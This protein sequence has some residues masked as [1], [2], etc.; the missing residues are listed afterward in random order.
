M[1]NIDNKFNFFVPITFEKAQ[2]KQG[3]KIMKI[4]GIASTDEKDSEGEELIP[5]GFVLDRF[6]SSGLINYNHGAKNSAAAVIG[7]PTVA[8]ITPKGEL[9]V[10][11][12][13]YSGHPLAESVY[14]LAETFLKN[15]SKRRLGFSIEGRALE[16]DIVNPK[17]ITKA[18]ITGLAVT[19]TP[20]NTST[21]LDI[22]KGEQKQDFIEYEYDQEDILKKSEVESEYLYEFKNNDITF[23]ITKSFEVVDIEKAQKGKKERKVAKVMKEW[24]EGKLK[25]GGSGETVTNRDQAIAIAMSEAGINKEKAMDI[26][27]T[28]PLI[29]EDLD[30]K[31]KVLEPTIVKAYKAGL[32]TKEQ[33]IDICKARAGGEGSRGGKVIGHTKSGKPIYDS[34]NHESHR[35]TF[36]KEDHNDAIDLHKKLM[37]KDKGNEFTH[38][39]QIEQHGNLKKMTKR[40]ESKR[41]KFGIS[42]SN[43]EHRI[44][45]S[46]ITQGHLDRISSIINQYKDKSPNYIDGMV[47]NMNQSLNNKQLAAAYSFLG[48]EDKMSK[49]ESVKRA[50]KSLKKSI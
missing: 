40:H 35:N 23:G 13:L 25:S 8:K 11:G 21:Y 44:R 29:P 46:T 33:V 39:N 1:K 45:R 14:A 42:L 10:E 17:K 26:A 7:E 47:A 15:K 38:Y 31:P 28:S 27:A 5:V 6:L 50:N 37:T 12:T 24:K 18:L 2:N 41:E 34:A 43:D 49:T 19:P 9:Y 48:L 36:T 3:E 30:G 20:V 4:S 22:V 16:R 32:L